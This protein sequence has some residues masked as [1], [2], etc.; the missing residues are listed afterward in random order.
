ME[1][2]NERQDNINE[3]GPRGGKGENRRGR[4]LENGTDSGNDSEIPL[5]LVHRM[6]K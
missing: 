3:E 6:E 1:R 4:L 5:M 2:I